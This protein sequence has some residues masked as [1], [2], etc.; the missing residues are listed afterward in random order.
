MIIVACAIAVVFS[1]FISR[2]IAG[3]ITKIL[4]TT[5]RIAE[6]DLEIKIKSETDIKELNEL[7]H[8]LN[9]MSS[10]LASREE[11]LDITNKKLETLNKSYLDLIGFVS[12][13]LKGILSSVVLNTYLLRKGILGPV[14]EKQ[15]KTLSSMTR[16]LDYLTVTVKNFLSLSRIEKQEMQ[17][18]K[19][20][21]FLKEHIFDVVLEA[22]DQRIKDKEMVVRDE[23]PGDLQVKADAS[24]LQIVA[25]NLVSNA[26]KYGTQGGV[27]R[28][29]GIEKDDVVEVE[30]YN[31]GQPIEETDLDKL[32]KK[33]S[34]V[35]YRGMEKTKGSGLGLYITKEILKMHGG[36]IKVI[37]RE[38]GNSFIIQIEKE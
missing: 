1:L 31:D 21:L 26:I 24:L 17:M 15:L 35:V 8:S 14:T 4:K 38:N 22:F 12:H 32:F 36:I 29:S 18:D 20:D 6:G 5:N 11:S 10:M 19:N 7:I 37:P 9:N 13:E 33:F 16:N 25:N 3:P 28:L 23:I 2:S 34:R 27:M 30:V